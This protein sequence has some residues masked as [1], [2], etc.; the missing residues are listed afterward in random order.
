MLTAFLYL[1][2]TIDT[3]FCALLVAIFA[4][5]LLERAAFCGNNFWVNLKR[6][7]RK[8]NCKLKKHNRLSPTS[9]PCNCAEHIHACIAIAIYMWVKRLHA[10]M[11]DLQGCKH[12]CGIT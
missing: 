8:N 5:I 12:G 10:H 3:M 1:F 4:W 2:V 9:Y 11:Q 6:I 7:A